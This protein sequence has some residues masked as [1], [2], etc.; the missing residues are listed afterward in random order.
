MNDILVILDD[1][2]DADEAIL[3]DMFGPGPEDENVKEIRRIGPVPEGKQISRVGATSRYNGIH[4]SNAII[5]TRL[6]DGHSSPVKRWKFPHHVS[7]SR[8]WMRR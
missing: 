8:R 7:S 1:E 2:R 4:A 3:E 5:C 6:L